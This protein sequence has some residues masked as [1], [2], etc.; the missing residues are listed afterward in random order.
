MLSFS[1]LYF[2]SLLIIVSKSLWLISLFVKA[3]DILLSMLF[4]LLLASIAVLLYFFFLFL[5]VFN[6]LFII[7]VKI[8]NVRLKL[9]LITPTG[10]P[11]TVANDTIETL[12]VVIDKKINDLSK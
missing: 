5:V 9:A 3:S 8:E 1:S 12:P 2:L 4:N 6:S 11:V 10:A 7:L